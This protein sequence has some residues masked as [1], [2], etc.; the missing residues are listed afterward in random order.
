MK[1]KAKAVLNYSI[2]YLQNI[3]P[4]LRASII[5]YCNSDIES[6]KDE[7]TIYCNTD[8]IVSLKK[9]KDLSFGKDIG[10]WKLEEQGLFAYVGYD[11]QW[12]DEKKTAVRGI[13]KLWL[14]DDFDIVENK[15]YTS[16]NNYYY[17]LDTRRITKNEI[18]S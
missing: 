10:Q 16:L 13:P 6:I 7:D 1:L 8:S 2:G 3:N 12:Y 9:R 4:F 5:S 14:D 11:Y 15:A 18:K 17:N